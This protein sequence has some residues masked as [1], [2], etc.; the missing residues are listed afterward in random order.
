MGG[1]NTIR[2][3][4]HANDNAHMG[5]G[6]HMRVLLFYNLHKTCFSTEP[7]GAMRKGR[8]KRVLY[9]SLT[10][11]YAIRSFLQKGSDRVPFSQTTVQYSFRSSFSHRALWFRREACLV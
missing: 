2:L 3:L 9:C 1:H 7:K 5:E 4:Y 11:R 10:E 8:T 6:Q